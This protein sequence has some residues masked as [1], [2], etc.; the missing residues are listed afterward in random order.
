MLFTLVEGFEA[1]CVQVDE[2]DEYDDGFN[3]EID[4][5]K[6]LEEREFPLFKDTSASLDELS[7]N[8]K[9]IKLKLV[10]DRNVST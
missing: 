1:G 5:D 3:D 8:K 10:Y 4:S 7:F 9:A 6:Q 2:P